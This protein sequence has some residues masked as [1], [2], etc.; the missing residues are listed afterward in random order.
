MK[1]IINCAA[2]ADGKIALPSGEQTKI[3]SEE[4]IARVHGLRASVDAILVGIDTVLKDDPKLTVKEKYAKGKN[5]IRVVLDSKLRIPD[6]ALVLNDAAPTIVFNSIRD[7][8]KGKAELVK[9]PE[10]NGLLDLHAVI[11]ELKKRGVKTL[12]VEGG[13]TVIWNFLKEGIADELDIFI[14]DIVIGG[15]KSPTVADG[16]GAKSMDDII[17]LKRIEARP[18]EGG[19]LLRYEVLHGKIFSR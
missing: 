2:S 16:R 3:S 13:G 10:R 19:I 15:E 5:P 18:M 14:G 17:R 8:K 7:G 12:L 9:C 6:K 11:S 1:T 4:D